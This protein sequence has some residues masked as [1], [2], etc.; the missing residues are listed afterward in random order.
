MEVSGSY[1]GLSPASALQRVL[2]INELMLDAVAGKAYVYVSVSTSPSPLELH[3][4]YVGCM[5]T[6]AWG[7]LQGYLMT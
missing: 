4:P 7:S 2:L 1:N 5:L 3:V 6:I